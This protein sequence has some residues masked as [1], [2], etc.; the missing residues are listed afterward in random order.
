MNGIY[1]S[2]FC[3]RERGLKRADYPIVVG[4]LTTRLLLAG[5]WLKIGL[6]AHRPAGKLF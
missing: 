1:I 2:R 3:Q 4:G 5:R 6:P